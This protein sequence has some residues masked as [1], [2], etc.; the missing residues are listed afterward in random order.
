[1]YCLNL[2][3]QILKTMNGWAEQMTFKMM[4]IFLC[5]I[6]FRH[7]LRLLESQSDE[8]WY[9][10]VVLWVITKDNEKCL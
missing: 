5:L 7:V 6:I 4:S 1:M 10:D 2:D 9:Y 8:E 3:L